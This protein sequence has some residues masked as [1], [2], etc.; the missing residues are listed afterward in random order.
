M[1]QLGRRFLAGWLSS[2]SHLEDGKCLL[3]FPALGTFFLHWKLFGFVEGCGSST[4]PK[5]R[6]CSLKQTLLPAQSPDNCIPLM[7]FSV[8]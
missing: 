6:M 3:V 8:V 5:G 1:L 7:G 4:F 2:R